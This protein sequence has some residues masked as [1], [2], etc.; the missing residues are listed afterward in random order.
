MG[1]DTTLYILEGW[2]RDYP[3]CVPPRRRAAAAAALADT[4]P[5][6]RTS[7]SESAFVVPNLLREKVAAGK[8]GRK[9]GEGFFKWEGNKR[10]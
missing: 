6:L 9:S 5:C 8:L 7:R 3:E 2:V 1:L 10:V 4:P